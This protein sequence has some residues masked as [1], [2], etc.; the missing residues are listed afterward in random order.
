MLVCEDSLITSA[1]VAHALAMSRF[2]MAVQIGPAKASKVAGRFGAV[3]S[4][5]KNSVANDVLFRVLD[6]DVA[7]GG[8]DVF[9]RIFLETFLGIVGENDIRSW[10]L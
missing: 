5:E 6:A 1:Q 10:G 3:I 7:V 9:F 8:S 2:D 4:Q